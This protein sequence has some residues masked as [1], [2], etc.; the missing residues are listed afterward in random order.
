MKSTS[1]GKIRNCDNDDDDDEIDN[2]ETTMMMSDD[3]DVN[4]CHGIALVAA[5]RLDAARREE[6]SAETPQHINIIVFLET[7][8]RYSIF[9]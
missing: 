1:Q 3:D 9:R 8:L 6:L 2:D 5:G 4:N 7:H